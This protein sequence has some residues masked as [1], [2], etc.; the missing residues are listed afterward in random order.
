MSV[1]ERDKNVLKH[2]I[3]Y[4][5]QIEATINRFGD[6]FDIFDQ[7][8]IYRNAASLCILQIG[9]L[10]GVLSD[11]FKKEHSSIP[12]AQIKKMR[13]IVAHRYGTVDSSITW[14]VMKEDIPGLRTYCAAVYNENK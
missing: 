14:D 5:D 10:V 1:D 8:I 11:E 2:I 9:E 3:N 6:D 7:D 4:C 12:W 13:N